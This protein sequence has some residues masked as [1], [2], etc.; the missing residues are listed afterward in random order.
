M[1]CF[2]N[3]RLFGCFDSMGGYVTPNMGDMWILSDYFNAI[4]SKYGSK[5]LYFDAKYV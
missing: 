5:V 3:S 1:T 2:R 4:L